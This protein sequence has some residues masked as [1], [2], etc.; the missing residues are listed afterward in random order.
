VVLFAQVAVLALVR[1]L[2]NSFNVS[3][4][5][6]DPNG[7]EATPASRSMR[8]IEVKPDMTL[9]VIRDAGVAPT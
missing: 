8:S 1:D 2:E 9:R 7:V 4:L 5:H 6:Q 3:V